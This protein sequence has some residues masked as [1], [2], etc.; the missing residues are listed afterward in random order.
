VMLCKDSK[1]THDFFTEW[2]KLWL[3]CFHQKVLTDQHSFNQANYILG[4]IITELPGEW[5]CQIV[6]D[7]AMKYLCNAKIIHYFTNQ[8]AKKENPFILSNQNVFEKI[9]KTGVVD[10]ELKDSLSV[11]RTLFAQNTRLVLIQGFEKSSILSAARKV[12]YS[13][14]GTV[15][16][17]VF[18]FVRKY[19]FTPLK[20]KFSK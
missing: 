2:H 7:G 9:K 10:Q 14:A 19:I 16:E 20:K 18:S 3:Y 11:S 13:K 17:A 6:M 5:N 4:N 1:I 12:F 8:Y 15:I